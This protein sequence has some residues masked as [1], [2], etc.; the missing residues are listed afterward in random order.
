MEIGRKDRRTAKRYALDLPCSFRVFGR[1]RS[2]QEGHGYARN[3]S[4][5]GLLVSADW[6]LTK[7]QPVEISIQLPAG[8]EGSVTTQLVVLGHVVRSDIAEAGVRIVRHGFM[9]VSGGERFASVQ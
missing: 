2:V 1:D 5:H 6:K 8:A 3:M 9:R 7:G 4:S